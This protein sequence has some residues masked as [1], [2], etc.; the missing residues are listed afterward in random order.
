[1]HP[2][3]EIDLFASEVLQL[4]DGP[5]QDTVDGLLMLGER[6]WLVNRPDGASLP[7]VAL[8]VAFRQKIETVDGIRLEFPVELGTGQCG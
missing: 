5:G 4:F 8:D 3:L 2:F 7:A 6:R 1:M